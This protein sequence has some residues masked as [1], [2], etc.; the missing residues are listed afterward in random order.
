[1]EE[2]LKELTMMVRA[3]YDQQLIMNA[4]IDG[5]DKRVGNI[6]DRLDRIENRMDGLEQRMDKLENRMDGLE[7]RMDKLE[8]RMDGLEQRMDKLENRMDQ[9]DHIAESLKQGTHNL[10]IKVDRAVGLLD[11]KVT[12]IEQE[13]DDTQERLKYIRT[14]L[15]RHDEEILA[16]GLKRTV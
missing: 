8:N 5:L 7:Q 1:M 9:V 14:V 6:E 10:D 16:L 2:Q 15:I 12:Q 13:G 11:Q 4:K 3:I